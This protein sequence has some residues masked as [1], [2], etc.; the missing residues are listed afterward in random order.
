MGKLTRHP[1]SKSK[2]LSSSLFSPRS[3]FCFIG[4][5]VKRNIAWMRTNWLTSPHPS[6]QL[7][8]GDFCIVRPCDGAISVGGRIQLDTDSGREDDLHRPVAVVANYF[9]ST[10]SS[11]SASRRQ[12]LVVCVSLRMQRGEFNAVKCHRAEDCLADN[13]QCGP[14]VY[15]NW[16]NFSWKKKKAFL[17]WNFVHF[18]ML[19]GSMG[20]LRLISWQRP[21]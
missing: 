12:Q 8:A 20:T 19:T 6:K 7:K 3:D 14:T 18:N 15:W 17:D 4:N 9:K 1:L 13:S 5:V 10:N 16:N 21:L 11:K 2:S